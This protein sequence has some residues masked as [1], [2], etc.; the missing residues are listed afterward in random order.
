MTVMTENTSTLSTEN[1]SEFNSA[2]TFYLFRLL[3]SMRQSIRAIEQYSRKLSTQYDVT[4]PQLICLATIGEN[5]PVAVNDLAR[6][7]HLSPSTVVGICNRLEKKE[8]LTRHAHPTDGRRTNLSLTD[9]G[10]SLLDEAPQPLQEKLATS[11]GKLSEE[12]QQTIV[13]SLEKIVDMIQA[14]DLDAAPVLAT[15]PL[16]CTPEIQN[17]FWQAVEQEYKT[18][19][20]DR[21]NKPL[22]I[23]PA[24]VDDKPDIIAFINSSVEWY[25]SIID[26]Q[27]LPQHAVNNQ[28]ADENMAKREFFVAESDGVPVGTLSMQFFGEY[29]YLGYVYIDTSQVGNGFGRKLLKFAAEEAQRRGMKGMA[30]IAHPQANWAIKAYQKFGFKLTY[31]DR[32]EILAWNGGV[33]KPYYEEYFMLFLYHFN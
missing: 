8:L 6:K 33:L 22:N 18:Q 20:K 31:R 13:T 23:R 7:V 10:K 30:L 32:E 19:P 28:W 9:A 4:A 1:N 29:A 3:Q 17:N 25:R 21:P 11:F 5:A 2:S 16:N 24:K 12:E 26:E 15:G 14:R 27:D